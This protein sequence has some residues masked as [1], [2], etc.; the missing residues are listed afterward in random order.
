MLVGPPLT[1]TLAEGQ[2]TVAAGDT[3]IRF[4]EHVQVQVSITTPG[5]RGNTQVYVVCPDGTRSTV[6]STRANDRTT[7]G[8]RAWTFMTVR[9]WGTSPIGTWQ[10][11]ATSASPA[12]TLTAVRITLHGTRVSPLHRAPT[13]AGQTFV[14]T[15]GPTSAPTAPTSSPTFA[16][17]LVTSGGQYCSVSGNC[18]TDG[19]GGHGNNEACQMLVVSAGTLSATEFE[20]E[21]GYDYVTIN[22]HQF[23]GNGL[24][25]GPT[26][27]PVG[28]GETFTWTSDASVTRAGWTICWAPPEPGEG[29]PAATGSTSGDHTVPPPATSEAPGDAGFCAQLPVARCSTVTC[30]APSAMRDF[31]RCRCL[32]DA[33]TPSPDRPDRPDVDFCRR[34]VAASTCAEL[35]EL[36]D[37]GFMDDSCC[38]NIRHDR[39]YYGDV[40]CTALSERLHCSASGTS[41][42]PPSAAGT[43]SLPTTGGN[44]SRKDH[45]SAPTPDGAGMSGASIA[46]LGA[47]VVVSVGIAVVVFRRYK[48]TAKRVTSSYELVHA[49]ND[50]DLGVPADLVNDE[51][52]TPARAK[53]ELIPEAEV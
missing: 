32:N 30:D 31:C 7:A 10:V 18:V 5:R 27:V 45:R 6:L 36:V 29:H 15:L 47:G 9:C 38:Q 23:S 37:A 25:N 35:A 16:V 46:A 41:S 52:T 28:A 12:A 24:N 26:H 39:L 40:P 42:L 2:L 17:L 3:D 20:T 50:L 19:N 44:S 13:T 34:I 48:P 21:S 49:S 51:D 22:G 33:T 53:L 43:T 8:F 11:T 1:S 4:L 14:P